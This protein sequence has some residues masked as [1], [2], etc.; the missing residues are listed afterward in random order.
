MKT[1]VKLKAM[2]DDNENNN[3]NINSSWIKLKVF[4]TKTLLKMDQNIL[5][6]LKKVYFLNWW[7]TLITEKLDWVYSE[8]PVKG[9]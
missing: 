7:L 6:D 2:I 3:N 8:M 9:M 1:R 5:I 4:V